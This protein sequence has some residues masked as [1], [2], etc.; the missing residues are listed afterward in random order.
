MPIQDTDTS[1]AQKYKEYN[2]LRDILSGKIAPA[3]PSKKVESSRFYRNVDR[4]PKATRSLTA[5]PKRKRE[6]SGTLEAAASP[7]QLLSPEGPAFIGPTPQRDGIVIGLF[8]H[9]S[10][11]TPIK[12]KGV[13]SE[14]E[15][16]VV[17][18]PSRR[19]T[20]SEVSLES[21]ARGEKTPQSVS[22]RSLLASFM[23][24]T[25][26]NKRKFGEQATPSSAAR[27]LATPAFLRRRQPLVKIDED[28][29]L[30]SRPAPWMRR[31]FGRSLSERMQAM[32]QEEE[33]RLDEDLDILHDLEME[34]EGLP[35]PKKLKPSEP[36]VENSQVAMPL[37]PDRGQESD[38]DCEVEA[39][40]ELG[41]DGKP[42]RVWKKRGL[43]RQ[44]RRVIS[45]IPLCVCC[46]DY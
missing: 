9:L 24:V 38:D 29:E 21:R 43:K 22:K 33:Q 26:S 1:P 17:Q 14:V 12:E 23:A 18:T 45:M 10:A 11:E 3:T 30:A 5:T 46:Y 2:K 41:P 32:R 7:D 35:L 6:D 40:D 44:T 16:N 28:E 37:G 15:L 19:D 4:T 8:D 13:L 25:P 39:A 31:S 42:K 20:G 27:G 34:A 36:Q